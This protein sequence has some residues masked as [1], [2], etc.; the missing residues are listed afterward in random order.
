M[1][2]IGGQESVAIELYPQ[3]VCRRVFPPEQPHDAFEKVGKRVEMRPLLT[4]RKAMPCVV[5]G[6]IGKFEGHGTHFPARA[7][8][9]RTTRIIRLFGKSDLSH[10]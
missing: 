6:E 1:Y 2:P 9:A 5:M 10:R 7:G 3:P 4:F 8:I